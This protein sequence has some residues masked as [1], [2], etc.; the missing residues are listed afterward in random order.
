[1][2]LCANN[3]QI[4]FEDYNNSDSL[5]YGIG[6]IG[7][8]DDGLGWAF[9]DWI[10]DNNICPKAEILKRYQLQLEDAD[11]LSYKKRVLF[12]DAS[13]EPELDSFQLATIEP[14]LDF[15]FTSHALSV[16][17]VLATCQTCFNY[18]PKAHFLTIKGYQWELKIGLTKQAENNLKHSINSII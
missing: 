15:S 3:I 18:T 4:D 9:I 14:K 16:G 13:M 11:L 5:I 7:R 12:I 10:E 2:K 17:A 6:N 1:M 8:Q